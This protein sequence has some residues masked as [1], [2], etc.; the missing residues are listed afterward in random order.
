MGRRRQVPFRFAPTTGRAL[1]RPPAGPHAVE[2]LFPAKFAK[3]KIASGCPTNDFLS[4]PR[5][6]LS[7]QILAVLR[8]RDF[9]NTHRPF[10][11]QGAFARIARHARDFGIRVLRLELTGQ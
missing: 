9:F 8:K 5:H 10:H 11:S 3:I 1:P 2:K 7:P 6:F 4:F